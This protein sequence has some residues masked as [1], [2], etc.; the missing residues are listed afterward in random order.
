MS[1]FWGVVFF[2][3]LLSWLLKSRLDL[4][5]AARP[6]GPFHQHCNMRA[7]AQQL[8][9][10]EQH[11]LFKR[12][13]ASDVVSNLLCLMLNFSCCSQSSLSQRP[14]PVATSVDVFISHSWSCPAWMKILA[15]CHHLNFD[16]AIILSSLAGMMA[17]LA[18]V[19]HAGS[20]HTVSQM[21]WNLLSFCLLGCP[22]VA[23]LVAYLFGHLCSSQTFWFD[24]LCVDQG[25]AMLRAQTLRAVPVSW[26]EIRRSPVDIENPPIFDRVSYI[27]TYN[28]WC[29]ISSINSMVC[30]AC[31]FKC[32][33]R[34]S[35]RV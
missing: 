1:V 14:L 13:K 31:F 35:Y 26:I 6:L 30:L 24:R 7:V 20:L 29:R 11:G 22:M 18:L 8:A 25:H 3:I 16:F 19:L 21:D 4:P 17:V 34:D 28:R 5:F 27:Y 2:E 23:F 15:I 32:T 33:N 10:A 9:L 12:A